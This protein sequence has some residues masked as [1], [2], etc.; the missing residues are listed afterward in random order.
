L[1]IRIAACAGGCSGLSYQMG[2]ESELRAGDALIHCGEVTVVIDEESQPL[3][4]GTSVDFCSNSA[5]TGF[6][7]DNPNACGSCGSRRTCGQ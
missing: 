3:L 7:F 5:A 4:R 1:G 2:L 6:V